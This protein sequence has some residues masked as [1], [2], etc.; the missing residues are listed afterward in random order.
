MDLF[1]GLGSTP[2]EGVY[3][4]RPPEAGNFLF[5]FIQILRQPL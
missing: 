4:G 5:C 1:A 3:K 2:G